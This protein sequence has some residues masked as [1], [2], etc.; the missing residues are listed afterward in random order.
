MY[1]R[2][3]RSAGVIAAVVGLPVYLSGSS[4]I[5][6]G[7][8]ERFG[9]AVVACACARTGAASN[10]PSARRAVGRD[11]GING[12]RDDGNDMRRKLCDRPAR[13]LG[14]VTAERVILRPGFYPTGPLM[15]QR[16]LQQSLH[17]R[18]L[19]TAAEIA[20]LARALD[21]E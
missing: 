2:V 17:A 1:S 9:A 16:D 11:N 20:R 13:H 7:A 14:T 6:F 5:V 19:A 3:M 8:A 4:S 15:L 21:P 18:T 10:T 12:L